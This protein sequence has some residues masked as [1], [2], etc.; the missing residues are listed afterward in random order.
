MKKGLAPV[1]VL[2]VAL[3]LVGVAV[4]SGRF[5]NQKPSLTESG[6]SNIFLDETDLCVSVPPDLVSEYLGKDIIKTETMTASGLESCQYY[7]D[8]THALVINHDLNSVDSKLKGHEVLGRTVTTNPAISMEHAVVIQDDGLINEIYLILGDSGFVS[9]NRPNG[10]IISETEIIDFAAKLARYFEEGEP[11]VDQSSKSDDTVP[12]PQEEDII[13]N[14]FALIDEQKIPEAINM[15]SVS[16]VPDD[17]A[18]QA[19]G[20]QFNDIKSIN[21]LKLEPSMPESWTEETHSYKVTLEAYVSSDAASAPIP[22][23]GWEDNPNIRWVELVKEGELWK[24][25]SIAT[26]P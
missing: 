14:F 1:L 13:R 22:Y 12:L 4:L 5:L 16:M 26:G 10:N 3:V 9:I 20:V 8:E 19:W 25:N 7:L 15:L 23:Y 21:V 17:S 11:G 24:I 18:K 6:E 2:I